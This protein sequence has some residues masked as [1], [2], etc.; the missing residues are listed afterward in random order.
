M[1]L[2]PFV[3]ILVAVLIGFGAYGLRRFNL[4]KVA[5]ETIELLNARIE[6][7]EKHS[8]ERD[9]AYISLENKCQVLQEMVTQAAAVGSLSQEMRE[10]HD[11]L[12][13]RIDHVSILVETV[14]AD[15][16]KG[17]A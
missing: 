17:R 12:L 2:Q 14:L 5:N 11:R 13:A 16:A 10:G 8:A 3:T 6:A 7:L 1:T 4:L 9:V 15:Q